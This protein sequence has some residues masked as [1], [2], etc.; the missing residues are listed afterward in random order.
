M[1]TYLSTLLF[2]TAALLSP[3]IAQLPVA[4]TSSMEVVPRA[5]GSTDYGV[6]SSMKINPVT[7]RPGIAH[8]DRA[9]GK[10]IYTAWNG[11]A[12]EELVVST[13]T[14]QAGADYF[15]CSLAYDAAGVPNIAF[16][17]R[18]QD[19]LK[20]ARP[21]ATGTAFVTELVDDVSYF[22][23]A[24]RYCALTFAP[25]GKAYLSYYHNEVN[26]EDQNNPDLETIITSELRVAT[27]SAAGVWSLA[28]VDSGG[29]VG[30][31]TSIALDR[32]GRP[33]VAYIDLT[34]HKAKVA[35]F[36]DLVWRK[37][38][39][40]AYPSVAF[41]SIAITAVGNQFDLNVAYQVE[42]TGLMYIGSL[43]ADNN[44]PTSTTALVGA[45]TNF[46]DNSFSCSDPSLVIDRNG[47][48]IATYF[49]QT[50]GDL[51]IARSFP[52]I[53]RSTIDTTGIVGV[54]S[55]LVIGSDGMASVCYR[56]ATAGTLKYAKLTGWATQFIDTSN[57]VGLGSSLSFGPEGRPSISYV[58]FTQGELN[59][60]E[61]DAYGVWNIQIADPISSPDLRTSLKFNPEGLPGISFTEADDNDLK[62]TERLSNGTWNS[63]TV[64]S[65]GD[66]GND[67]SLGFGVNGR[68]GISYSDE[69]NG[70][71][72]YAERLASGPWSMQTV[73]SIGNVG[74]RTSLVFGSEGHPAISYQDVTQSDLKFAERRVDGT[75]KIQTIDRN[76]EPTDI[77]SSS[78]CIS[79][80]G[81]WGIGY[82]DSINQDL[83][84]AERRAN[85]TWSTQ[86]IESDGDKGKYCSLNFS[87]T[88]CPAISYQ[89]ETN[90]YLK[91]TE[92]LAD[93]TWNIQW[94]DANSS[95]TYGSLGFTS[96]GFTPEGQPA[97][98]Y[99]DDYSL[100]LK[101]A[102]R[103]LSP[104][105]QEPTATFQV[106]GLTRDP[107]SKAATLGWLGTPGGK[108]RVDFSPTLAPGS[109]Q[110][111]GDDINALNGMTFFSTSSSL[112]QSHPRAFFRVLRK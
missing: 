112:G 76:G 1:K 97:I 26:F 98:S 13:F 50:N 100:N 107:V 9:A 67:S 68:I 33:A 41:T 6:R 29:D 93:G 3:A 2:A 77:A 83:K 87:P 65:S 69:T 101:Y 37:G 55:S 90:R 94:V 71:L 38:D 73:D 31:Y 28:T 91:F 99:F 36:N 40:G 10:L 23:T 7:G 27:R 103:F 78:L 48:L 75:W 19:N 18:E 34:R 80:V 70:D 92:R 66:V 25:N 49:D 59:Y 52:N 35:Y 54:W 102:E 44:G 47:K 58:N 82:Y 46:I 74:L 61:R 105:P 43:R 72:K 45:G 32:N 81:R 89:D 106:L 42:G 22:G 110:P 39:V 108:Y 15:Y 51:K 60:A 16:F 20:F 85:G 111:I 14:R 24:G 8:F 21:N 88:G 96:L 86:I 17:D 62:Y 104:H 5:G 95:G 4:T 64:D 11:A 56:D 57:F 79:P 109:W 12:W 63:Q 84:Y 30:H 53:K